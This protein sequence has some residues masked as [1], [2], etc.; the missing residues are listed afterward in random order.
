MAVVR[1]LT[2]DEI[3]ELLAIEGSVSEEEIVYL[4]GLAARVRDGCIVQV[5]SYRG[6]S[7][8]ALALGSLAGFQVPVYAVDPQEEF[9]GIYGRQF[10]P[11][12]RGAFFQTMP[13]FRLYPVVR[14]GNLSSEWLSRR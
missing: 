9:K 5:G 14:L 3:R 12:D 10:G 4:H 2:A 1:P 6:R 11:E 13:R 7:T 8:A